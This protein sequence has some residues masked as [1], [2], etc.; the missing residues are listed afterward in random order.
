MSDIT[1]RVRDI[2]LNQNNRFLN[3]KVFSSDEVNY[4]VFKNLERL[5][6]K[7]K[8]IRAEKGLY[9]IPQKSIFGELPLSTNDFI[10]KYLYTGEKRI[11]YITGNNLFNK[12]AMDFFN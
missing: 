8:L 9:Y 4:A 2:L 5:V 12:I 11:G 6:K 10:Q 3:T 7:G 1:I